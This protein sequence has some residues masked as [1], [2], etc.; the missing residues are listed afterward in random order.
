MIEDIKE[1]DLFTTDTRG[2]SLEEQRAF[3]LYWR[4][5]TGRYAI[6]MDGFEYKA[7]LKYGDAK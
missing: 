6:V 1:F 5:Q 4:R 2:M 7:T 3:E